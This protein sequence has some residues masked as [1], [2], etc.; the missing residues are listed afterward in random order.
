M[1]ANTKRA[2]TA[3]TVF[4]PVALLYL[5]G[6]LEFL[7]RR[8][9]ETRFRLDNRPLQSGVVLVDIDPQS[10]HTLPTWPWPRGYHATV[11]DR[12]FE[13]GASRVAI[14]IDFSSHSDPQEDAEL[15]QAVAKWR[16]RVVLPVFQQGGGEGPAR[17][18]LLE[19]LPALQQGARL[20]SI[21]VQA[22]S[23]GV[24][25]RYRGQIQ[26]GD[27][28]VPSFAAALSG[29]PA[30]IAGES[31]LDFSIPVQTVP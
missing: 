2:I 7:E 17:L 9:M 11:L 24:V 5:A 18:A 3:A 26:F 22:D 30:S 6:G 28:I 21:N 12:L 4:G 15:A 20:G 1:H 31:Y 13:A 8:W 14:D 27:T 29:E 25:R 23:D 16:D 10:L 19:P